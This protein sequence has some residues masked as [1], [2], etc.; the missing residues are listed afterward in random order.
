[1][2]LRRLGITLLIVLLLALAACSGAS[3]PPGQESEAQ[4]TAMQATAAPPEPTSEPEATPTTE[5]TVPAASEEPVAVSPISLPPEGTGDYPWW[6]D[7]VWYEVFVRSFYDSDGDGVGDIQ[8]LIQKLDY[9]NDGDPTTRDDLGVTGLWLMPIME[10]PSYHG[11]DVVDYYKVDEEYGTEEDFQQL[12]EE[13]HARGMRVIVDMVLNHTSSEHPWFEAAREGDPEYEDWYVFVEGEQPFQTAPWG[14]G[15]V[16][17]PAQPGEERYYY[18]VFW[19]G[20]PDLNFRSEEVT[21]EMEAVSRFWLEEMGAD[22]FRLDAIRMLIE[23]GNVTENAPETHEWLEGFY[24][25]YKGIDEDIVMVGEVWTSP[26]AVAPYIGDEIDV[27]FEFNV[28]ESILSAA[29]SKRA[30]PIQQAYQQAVDLFPANQYAPFITNH[31]Q[32]RAFSYLQKKMGA[33]RVAAG[34]L[35]TGPGTPF[36]YYGE[37]VAMTGTKPDEDIRKPMPWTGEE[38][39][40]F[41]EAARPWRD[42]PEGYEENNVAAMEDDPDSLLNL[43]R[44]LIHLRNDHEA[45]RVGDYLAVEASHRSV[46]AFVRQTEGETLLVIHNLSDEAVSDYTLALED[47]AQIAEG[48]PVEILSGEEMEAPEMSGAGGFTEYVPMEELAP[49]TS[50][51]IQLR[52]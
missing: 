50:Y 5:P 21:A 29:V 42:F 6:N 33:M 28:A 30:A 37:E 44:R 32:N 4:P 14:G 9:L 48:I 34:I 39:A 31:D 49:Q 52:P 19:S 46:Y 2:N 17:Y 10:S 20:M 7:T 12:M 8:G 27:A 13:A 16:W 51:V 41:T 11:Y 18:G 36:L 23:E 3:Q 26:R 24:E 38:N 22:G 25:F 40:G 15:N 43:Y 1:M 45:L 47:G 35:L